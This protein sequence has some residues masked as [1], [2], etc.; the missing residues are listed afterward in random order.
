VRGQQ[1]LSKAVMVRDGARAPLHHEA[2]P[3]QPCLFFSRRDARPSYARNFRPEAARPSREGVG[4]AGC[5]M[6]PQPRARM[7]VVNA[8]EYSQRGHRNRPAFP[9][10][11]VLR[12]T[13]CSPRRSA[14]LP[15][16]PRG[17]KVLSGPVEPNEP[18]RDLTP[19]SRRQDHTTSP[20]AATRLRQKASPGFG[21]VRL[22]CLRSLTES[23]PPCDHIA[24]LTLPRPPH[25]IPRP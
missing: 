4:N 2:V 23:N 21:A 9:H 10:A 6:H 11:M 8:H 16:S 25:L 5:P 3:L 14:V 7:V 17:L 22:A 24:R 15:P 19:A 1:G 13:S 20:Y 18:P 12:L